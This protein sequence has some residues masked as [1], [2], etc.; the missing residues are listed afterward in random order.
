MRHSCI[1][2]VRKHIAQA[3]V[4]MDESKLGYPHH[5]WIAVGHLAE[6]ESESLREHPDFSR[7]IRA[8]RVAIMNKNAEE[9][10]LEELLREACVI[11]GDFDDL[12]DSPINSKTFEL[13]LDLAVM[14]AA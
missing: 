14:E 6:A 10:C 8:C 11:A 2:C 5:R 1:D 12:A 7:T 9:I 3:I 13:K 4:L